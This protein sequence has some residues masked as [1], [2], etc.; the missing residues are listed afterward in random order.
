[1][2]V[3]HISKSF[4][5]LKAVDDISFDIAPHTI[6]G[7]IGPNGAGKSSL[8]NCLSGFDAFDGGS[9]ILDGQNL[10]SGKQRDFFEAGVARTFQNTS[11]FDDMTVLENI[12]VAL[13]CER[14][15]DFISALL[16]KFSTR[17]GN[18]ENEEAAQLLLSKFSLE[19][20]KDKDCGSLGAGQRRLVEVVRACALQPKVVLLDEPAAGLNA[21]ETSH[22]MNVIKR[23]CD[24]DIAV[25]VVEHDIR[26][27]MGISDDIICMDRGRKIA[28]GPPHIIQKDEAVIEA[29]LGRVKNSVL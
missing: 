27:I 23:I 28:Q 19:E 14:G 18:G 25:I 5:G 1:M 29:Y 15:A 13:S 9:V 16:G 10:A 21:T 12:I 26:L 22:L 4:G 8:F 6:T 3:A 24:M 20:I 17:N 11:L 2:E 7:L